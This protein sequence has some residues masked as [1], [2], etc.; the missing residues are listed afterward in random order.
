MR[1]VYGEGLE[2]ADTATN[3][4]TAF[5]DN[6]MFSHDQAYL[7]LENSTSTQMNQGGTSVIHPLIIQTIALVPADDITNGFVNS[8]F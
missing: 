5:E 1:I 4:L 8:K 2:A 7:T 6:G 3:D